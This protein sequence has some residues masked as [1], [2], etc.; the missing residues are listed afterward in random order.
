M[1]YAIT[2]TG[3]VTLLI[4]AGAFIAWALITAIWIPKRNPDFPS[5]LTG[6]LLVAVASCSAGRRIAEDELEE[7]TE[8]TFYDVPSAVPGGAPG[9][10]VRKERLLGANLQA[11]QLGR[12]HVALSDRGSVPVVLVRAGD[13]AVAVHVDGVQGSRE[14]VV[15]SLGPQFAG[16][17]GISGATIL[18]DG[19]VALIL[20][21]CGVA[22]AGGIL[23]AANVVAG[24]ASPDNQLRVRKPSTKSERQE[25]I[26]QLE[27]VIN[28][29]ITA[30]IATHTHRIGR[31]GRV[32]AE[33]W[34]F[35]LASLDE[36]GRVGQIE[37]A[38]ECR[39]GRIER[40]IGIRLAPVRRRARR[41]PRNTTPYARIRHR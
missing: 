35:S 30:E 32:D 24:G 29:D 6:F 12:D 2:T 4:V 3:K 26:A 10:L 5:A 17:G 16:V 1:L 28:V 13:R 39:I 11:L 36:M 38:I 25:M 21:V 7:H 27:A 37:Q 31:T 19:S 8:G 18:G 15:K 14:I 40:C 20:D 23:T 33:G 9:T 22:A 41:T 34:A